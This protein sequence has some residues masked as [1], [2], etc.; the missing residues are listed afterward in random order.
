[1]AQTKAS[2]YSPV[3]SISG[4]LQ[5]FTI[6]TLVDIT[7]TGDFNPYNAQSVLKVGGE[8]KSYNQAQNLNTLLQTIS[9]R[10][11]PI[12]V[13]DVRVDTD[14]LNIGDFSTFA[15][16]GISIWTL[17]FATEHPQAITLDLLKEELDGV[18]IITG[19]SGTDT[20]YAGV[21]FASSVF[22]TDSNSNSSL[23]KN[24]H[25]VQHEEL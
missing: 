6:K 5:F 18:P 11:Q 15:D 20:D 7:N 25:F 4:D 22:V 19:T 16:D 23:N 3:E 8:K 1:M 2:G 21:V 24:I 17:K 12:I 10:T 9:L 14:Q 13:G